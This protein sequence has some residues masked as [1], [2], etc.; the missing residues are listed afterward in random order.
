MVPV[1]AVPN[2]AVCPLLRTP[3]VAAEPVFCVPDKALTPTAGFAPVR[4]CVFPAVAFASVPPVT[5]EVV[6]TTLPAVPV[7]DVEARLAGVTDTDVPLPPLFKALAVARLPLAGVFDK[8]LA[9]TTGL[10]PESAEVLETVTLAGLFTPP[11]APVASFATLLA[12]PVGETEVRLA[13]VTDTED[14]PLPLFKA[15]AVARLPLAGELDKALT[16]TGALV[17]ESAAVL[18]TVTFAGLFSPLAG[19]VSEPTVPF[20]ETPAVA[21]GG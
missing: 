20:V 5:P 19:L 7:G 3:A 17:P 4:T 18:P 2:V 16:P 6:L 13:G 10:V 9:P 21:D 8:A 15:L 14:A 12:V 1:G 11:T